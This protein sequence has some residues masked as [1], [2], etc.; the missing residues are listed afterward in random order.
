MHMKYLVTNL[1]LQQIQVLKI[2]DIQDT[3]LIL[4]IFS[5]YVLYTLPKFSDV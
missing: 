4:W 1:A 2:P 5:K 3:V